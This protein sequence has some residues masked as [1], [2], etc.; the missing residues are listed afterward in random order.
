[1]RG[2]LAQQTI[3]V[4]PT[5]ILSQ[6]WQVFLTY[7]CVGFIA[8][9]VGCKDTRHPDEDQGK[10]TTPVTRYG[11]TYHKPLWQEPLTLD[12]AFLTD[13][14]A[15]SVAQNLF[16]GLVQFDAK[17]NVVPSIAKSWEASR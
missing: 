7:L 2:D 16:D 1:M 5:M 13:V 17:L 14:F 4:R 12:P 8:L 10:S 11:G 3:R 9:A 15:T 6:R